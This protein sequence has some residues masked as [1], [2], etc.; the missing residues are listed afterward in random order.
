[1][2]AVDLI[3]K[4]RN[5]LSVSADEIQFLIDGYVGGEIPDY[6]IAAFVMAVYFNGMDGSEVG[7]LTRAMINSGTTMD[8]AGLTGP[9]VD[10]HSTGGVGDKVSLILAPIAAACGLQVPMMSGR[11]LGHTGGTLDKL[12]SIAG[13]GTEMDTV[14]FK[15]I[16]GSCGYAMTGQSENIVPADRLLYSLR[17]VTGTVESVPLITASI[18]SKK[19]A[20]GAEALVFD[21]KSG[22][23]AFMKTLEDSRRLAQSLIDTG[24]SLDRSI[25]AVITRMSEPLGHMVGNFL[26]VVESVYCLMGERAPKDFRYPHDL[27]TVTLRLA[28]WML[29]AGEV[30][31]DVEA[32]ESRCREAIADGSA[33]ERFRC[34]VAA[35]GGDPDQLESELA[36]RRAPVKERL[37]AD[38]DGFVTEIDAFQ[39]GMAGVYLGAGRNKTGDDVLDDVGVELH[40]K[41]GDKA[42]VGDALCTI[43]AE[44]QSAVDEAINRVREAYQIGPSASQPEGL[45]LDELTSL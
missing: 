27:M 25:V 10:K 30:V 2:R 17:D 18:M 9:L 11:A 41:V 22:S 29:V 34:N 44:S 24:R 43:Y 36:T 26:E 14:R 23:G 6:Q 20:E 21:V 7:A 19:F 32:A 40:V 31:E 1:M 33:Y 13:Y 16:I 42:S 15:S 38:R 45:I 28:A 35:Q 37:V 4:K 8:L 5:G 39:V 12:E 3:V